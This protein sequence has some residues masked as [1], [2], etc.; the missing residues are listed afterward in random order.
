VINSDRPGADPRNFLQ[1]NR[2]PTT[3]HPTYCI[4]IAG[5]RYSLLFL[6]SLLSAP[7]VTLLTS[8]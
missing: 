3:R 7:G 8:G 6:F 4:F 2:L 5:I 1:N